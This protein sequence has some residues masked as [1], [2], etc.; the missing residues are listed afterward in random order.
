M[1]ESGDAC[2]FQRPDGALGRIEKRSEGVREAEAFDFFEMAV[3]GD[4][5]GAGLDS[6]ARGAILGRTD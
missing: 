2:Q 4:E 6:M 1:D 5:D 3:E